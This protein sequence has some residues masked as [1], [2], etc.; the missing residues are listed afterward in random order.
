MMNW[1]M[2]SGDPRQARP[3]S[4]GRAGFENGHGR[5]GRRWRGTFLSD[6][7][8]AT[9]HVR[10]PSVLSHHANL[11]PWFGRIVQFASVRQATVT[12]QPRAKVHAIKGGRQGR[13]QIGCGV[14]G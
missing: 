13:R 5:R 4:D 14:V 2:K 1:E 8:P 9:P 11:R 3:R 12:R 7:S 10:N 6:T